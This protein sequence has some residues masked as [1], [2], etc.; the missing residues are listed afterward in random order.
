MKVGATDMRIVQKNAYPWNGALSFTLYP[1][2]A[3]S[4]SFRLRIPGWA[5]NEAIPSGLYHFEQALQQQAV[6]RVNGKEVHYTMDKGYAVLTQQWKS[7]DVVTLDLPMPVRRIQADTAVK[8]DIGR[9]ALQRGPL[10]YCAEWKD[11]NGLTSNLLMPKQVQFT[12]SYQPGMLNGIMVLHAKIPAVQIEG[13]DRIATKEQ[14]LTAIPYYSWAN[15]GVGEMQ[16]W[17]PEKI[18][19]FDI[20]SQ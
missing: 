4:F 14:T 19:A 15:R 8:A 12:A 2:K 16:V 5:R 6:I 11:N 13:G 17:F 9:V 7:G 1:E 3:T 10:I 20:I 18:K